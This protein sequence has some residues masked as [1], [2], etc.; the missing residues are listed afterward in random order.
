MHSNYSKQKTSKLRHERD[1]SKSSKQCKDIYVRFLKC[2]KQAKSLK[3]RLGFQK[4]NLATL[5]MGLFFKIV[6]R[7]EV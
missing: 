7:Q 5:G 1:K 3:K 2:L 6:P 4:Y